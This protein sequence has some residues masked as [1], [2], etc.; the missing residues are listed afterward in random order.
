MAELGGLGEGGVEVGKDEFS[1]GF[2]E[3]RDDFTDSE[4]GGLA[5]DSGDER[6]WVGELGLRRVVNGSQRERLQ[7]RRHRRIRHRR[8][9]LAEELVWSSIR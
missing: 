2:G 1:G 9:R 4:G 8:R 3:R 7:P 6:D 5:L